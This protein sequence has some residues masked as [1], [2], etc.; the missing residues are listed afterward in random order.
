MLPLILGGLSLIV[1]A[2][3][4]FWA[5][6]PVYPSS[7]KPTECHVVATRVKTLPVIAVAAMVIM[8]ITL[9]VAMSKPH[10]IDPRRAAQVEPA[11]SAG[12][13]PAR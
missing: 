9:L 8:V 3:I 11:G 4:G 10:P 13:Q 6:P 5:S 12:N 1:L 7:G 2:W